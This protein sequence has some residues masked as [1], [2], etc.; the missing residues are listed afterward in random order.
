MTSLRQLK[1]EILKII[2]QEVGKAP[3]GCCVSCKEPYSD[4]NVFT[5]AGWRETLLSGLCEKCFDSMFQEQP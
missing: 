2:E 3:P 4:K 5:Q 1:G